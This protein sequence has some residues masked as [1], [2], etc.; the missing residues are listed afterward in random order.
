LYQLGSRRKEL[1]A[2]NEALRGDGQLRENFAGL[3]SST[4]IGFGRVPGSDARASKPYCRN[5]PGLP[6]AVPVSSTLSTLKLVRLLPCASA[7]L[8]APVAC[9]SSSSALRFPSG[10][11]SWVREAAIRLA[12]GLGDRHPTS[13]WVK[14]GPYTLIAV[15]GKFRCTSC[16]IPYGQRAPTGTVAAIQIDSHT[17]AGKGGALCHQPDPSAC[18]EGLCANGEC[19]RSRYALDT[20]LTALYQRTSKQGEVGFDRKVGFHRNCG[21]RDPAAEYGVIKGNCR[22][23]EVVEPTR[24]AVTFTETWHGLDRSG[25]RTAKGPLRR[26]VWRVVETGDAWVRAF[27]STGDP[28][29]QFEAVP[30]SLR[31]ERR[32]AR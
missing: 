15:T 5:K 9:G 2:R 27:S 22:V 18:V 6:D 7:D 17:H 12:Q 1:G 29:P 31:R 20:A 16:S 3:G 14:R 24:I 19:T 26:H 13:V 21:L 8:L 4:R 25:R 10:T 28:P 23:T 30:A 11:P 32:S